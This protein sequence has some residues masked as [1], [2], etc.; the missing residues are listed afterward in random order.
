MIIDVHNHY[1]PEKIAKTYGVTEG[2]PVIIKEDGIPKR[3]IHDRQYIVEKR[4]LAMDAAGI[5]A[6]LVSCTLGWNAPLEECQ[7]IN[8]QLS[9]LQKQYDGKLIG[10]AD[11]PLGWGKSDKHAI[12]EL[13]RAIEQLGLRGV[14][15]TAQPFDI[16][17]DD[18][19]FWTFY[20]EVESMEVG[21]FIH[22]SPIPGG[23]EAL[24]KYDLHRVIGREFDLVT[25]ICRIIHGGILDKFPNIKLVF[26]HFGGGISALLERI[27]PKVVP[28]QQVPLSHDFEQYLKKLYFDTAGF[29]G[30]MR[31]FRLAY[32]VLGPSQLIFGSDYPQDFLEGE[33][34]KIYINDINHYLST[35]DYEKIMFKNAM[36]VFGLSRYR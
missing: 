27:V 4:L 28:W 23:F 35:E 2:K 16:P 14:S 7:F 24:A 10:L 5:I 31:A 9:H 11:V 33:E 32:E 34:I 15:M 30:G 19:K 8:D 6:Q 20:K 1:V 13:H 29:G 18:K 26:A 22:P 36:S 3:M 25:A 12:E 17:L 21:V